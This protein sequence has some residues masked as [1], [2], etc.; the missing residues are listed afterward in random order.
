MKAEAQVNIIYVAF[1]FA[2]ILIH[3][4]NVIPLKSRQS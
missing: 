3:A 2:L 1:S 4:E